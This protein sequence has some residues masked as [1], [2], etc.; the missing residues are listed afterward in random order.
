MI[1]N[2]FNKIFKLFKVGILLVTI[3]SCL[4][5]EEKE[6]IKKNLEKYSH[7]H[8]DILVP[9]SCTEYIKNKLNILRNKSDLNFE[10]R[11]FLILDEAYS[12]IDGYVSLRTS[13]DY[14]MME[15]YNIETFLTDKCYATLELFFKND[16]SGWSHFRSK[17]NSL[18]SKNVPIHS[19]KVTP[20]KISIF[21]NSDD[22]DYFIKESKVSP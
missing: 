1:R 14:S 11:K 15:L 16:E 7:N 9:K 18:E 2:I 22:V 3:S 10:Y 6:R 21:I 4:P 5:Q 13:D 12:N 8:L 20:E 17:I 19:I